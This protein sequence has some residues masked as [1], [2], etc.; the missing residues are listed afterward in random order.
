M[1]QKKEIPSISVCF[2]LQGEV[3]FFVGVFVFF[4]FLNK[5]E[6]NNVCYLFNNSYTCSVPC[7]F[8]CVLVLHT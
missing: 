4:S 3:K 8:P 1:L 5:A 6:M 7:L 2:H